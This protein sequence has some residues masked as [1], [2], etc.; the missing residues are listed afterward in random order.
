MKRSGKDDFVHQV[1]FDEFI[2][3]VS[4]L[5]T[6]VK[7]EVG[8]VK[9]KISMYEAEVERM[10]KDAGTVKEKFSMYEA[11]VERMKKDAEHADR[12]IMGL[13]RQMDTVERKAKERSKNVKR[14]LHE[15]DRMV[16]TVDTRVTSLEKEMKNAPR[17]DTHYHYYF[18]NFGKVKKKNLH[19]FQEFVVA[20]AEQHKK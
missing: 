5:D 1:K 2:V 16:A 15:M 18:N 9:E 12:A 7:R 19:A 11:E 3:Q 14:E 20:Q 10:K 17:G 6:E 4:S 13:Q 8:T